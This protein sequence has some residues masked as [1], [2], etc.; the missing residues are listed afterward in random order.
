MGIR[1]RL[2]NW[3]KETLADIKDSLDADIS[4][5]ELQASENQKSG[6]EDYKVV[7]LTPDVL[8]KLIEKN[9]QSQSS[10]FD[11]KE[12]SNDLNAALKLELKRAK[13]L[14]E[15]VKKDDKNRELIAKRADNSLEDWVVEGDSSSATANAGGQQ[16][17]RKN[18]NGG[19]GSGL[20]KDQSRDDY[21]R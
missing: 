2:V 5:A 9:D 8:E 14:E 16:G 7:T 20:K 18:M 4:E 17:K 12:V 10:D 6:K 15:T 21:E 3:G 19:K 11:A 13:E 1:E